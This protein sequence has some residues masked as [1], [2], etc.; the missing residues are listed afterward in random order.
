MATTTTVPRFLLPQSGL[1]WRGIARTTRTGRV[2][3]RFA[4]TKPPAS[5]PR[6]LEKP[7][8]FN[9]PSHGSRL[10]RK[11]GPKHYGGDLSQEEVAAQTRKEYPGMMAPV[12]SLAYRIISSKWIHL[13]ITLKGTLTSLA[14]W[15]WSMNLK[16]NSPFADMIPP[17]KDF[18]YHPFSSLRTLFEVIRLDE[19]RTSAIV[20]EK[21]ERE[22]SDVG[23]R[24]RYRTAHGLPREQGIE[25]LFGLGK[26]ENPAPVAPE[27]VSV[28]GAAAVV[29][30]T[31]EP[32]APRKKFL[33][34]F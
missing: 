26:E 32:S 34:I 31:E 4:S 33:G 19:L 9:P 6:V 16:R 5:G 13:T 15:S 22:V 7:E 11:G 20:A 3:I 17:G 28:D 10:P 1:I 12:G 25:S 30:A 29:A 27:A 23:K 14:L 18:L 8:R 24:Q 2:H 21:R